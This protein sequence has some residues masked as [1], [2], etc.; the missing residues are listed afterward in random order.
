MGNHL[1]L[2]EDRLLETAF[3]GLTQTE[4]AGE[5]VQAA[6]E[7]H[8]QHMALELPHEPDDFLQSNYDEQKDVSQTIRHFASALKRV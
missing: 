5:Y 1:C 2:C 6:L 8:W 4:T 7:A 3:V